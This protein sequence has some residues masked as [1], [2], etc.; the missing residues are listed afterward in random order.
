[1]YGVLQPHHLEI[2]HTVVSSTGI[3]SV[4]VSLYCW[5]PPH[6]YKTA[7]FF[8]ANTTAMM[9]YVQV[10]VFLNVCSFLELLSKS[11][12]L[13]QWKVWLFKF[14]IKIKQKKS[15]FNMCQLNT[16]MGLGIRFAYMLMTYPDQIWPPI[17]LHT[18]SPISRNHYSAF[19]QTFLDNTWER[20]N[21][22]LSASH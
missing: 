19:T 5:E 13:D 17:L 9:C 4:C 8:P 7:C 18:H 6:V 3:P 21:P 22:C 11:D 20:W 16:R 12:W 15:I 2:D 14:L 1:M 10:F